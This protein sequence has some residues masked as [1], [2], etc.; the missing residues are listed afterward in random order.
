MIKTYQS[1]LLSLVLSVVISGCDSFKDYTPPSISGHDNKKILD[2]DLSVRFNTLEPVKKWWENLNDAQLNKLIEQALVKNY[3]IK[4]ARENLKASRI[5]IEQADYT[6]LPI[7]TSSASGN[8]QMISNQNNFGFTP[9]DRKVGFFTAGFDAVWE[10][11]FFNRISETIKQAQADAQ[12]YQATLHAT[13]VSVTAEIV[14]NYIL[15]RGTQ[16]RLM[17]ARQIIDN[18]EKTVRLA[19]LLANSGDGD[20]LGVEQAKTQLELF[21]LAVP[22]LEAA[23]Q[24]TKYRYTQY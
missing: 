20:M 23:T 1:F 3:D 21:R 10:L 24:L 5:I 7:I 17:V 19:T 14:R 22:P 13:S 11:D 16:Q 15:L 4:I 8:K 9:A 18:A 6:R 12:A 2:N